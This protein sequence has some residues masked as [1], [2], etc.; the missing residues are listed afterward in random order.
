MPTKVT[1]Y[2]YLI[3]HEALSEAGD[4]QSVKIW[5]FGKKDSKLVGKSSRGGE[6]TGDLA[7]AIVQQF[8]TFGHMKNRLSK[9]PTVVQGSEW[10]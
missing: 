2:N 10:G 7:K 6:R 1:P 5:V 4:F 3:F 9:A 8:G